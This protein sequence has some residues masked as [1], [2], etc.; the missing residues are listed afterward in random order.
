MELVISE[1][2]LRKP[3]WRFRN[4]LISKMIEPNKTIIDIGCG[5]KNFLDYYDAK[6]Y[7]GIDGMPDVGADLVTDLNQDFRPLVDSGWDYA[8]NSGMIEFVKDVRVFLD[9]QKHLA[10]EYIF[11]WHLDKFSGRMSFERIEDIIK[12][13]YEILEMQPWGSQRVYRCKPI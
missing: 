6:K 13:N 5:A 10:N 4:K 2:H 12:E 9:R 1:L 3:P 11:T 7:F 8:I